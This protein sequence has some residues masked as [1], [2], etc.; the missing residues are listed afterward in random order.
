MM[1]MRVSNNFS[2]EA[3]EEVEEGAVEAEVED[4]EKIDHQKI[5]K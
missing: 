4:K 3:E 2:Q 5:L 1:K